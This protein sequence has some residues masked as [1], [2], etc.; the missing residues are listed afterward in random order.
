MLA[1]L[2]I[3]LSLI[4]ANSSADD[5]SISGKKQKRTL[6]IYAYFEVST[7]HRGNLSHFLARGIPPVDS[8][9]EVLIV[10]SGERSASENEFDY[11][12]HSY[13]Y[14]NLRFLYRENIDF[15]FGAWSAGLSAEAALSSALALSSFD[16]YVF[17]NA[18]VRG[19]FLSNASAFVADWTTLLTS[20][21]DTKTKLVGTTFNCHTGPNGWHLQSMVLA[22]DNIG[23]HM[24]PQ[25]T[26]KV[27]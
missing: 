16:Y 7:I 3:L 24:L 1:L 9:T 25:A 17:M 18:S 5:A 2:L 22:T 4:L 12:V 23:V 21:I 8:G 26:A 15:D 6:V 13:L 19:P 10:V 27:S 14:P 20:Y 11:N